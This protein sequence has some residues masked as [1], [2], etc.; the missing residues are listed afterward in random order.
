M[1]RERESDKNRGEMS[2]SRKGIHSM[3]RAKT[4]ERVPNKHA[5]GFLSTKSLSNN[6]KEVTKPLTTNALN[7][8]I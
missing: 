1:Q 3:E 7:P 2:E 5:V 8:A 4:L 6:G